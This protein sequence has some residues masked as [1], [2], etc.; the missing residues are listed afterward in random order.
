MADKIDPKILEAMKNSI[1]TEAQLKAGFGGKAF[2]GGKDVKGFGGKGMKAEDQT[3]KNRRLESGVA[4]GEIGRLAKQLEEQNKIAQDNKSEKDREKLLMDLVLA[5]EKGD[6]EGE[7]NALELRATYIATQERLEK[8]I[9]AGDNSLIELEQA[10]LDRVMAGAETEEKRREAA[11]ATEK[12]S[13]LLGKISSGIKGLSGFLK[14]NAVAIG[15]GLFAGLALFAPELMEKLVK[16]L[17]SVLQKAMEIVKALLDGDI[18]GALEAFKS[19]WLAFTGAFIFFF[20]DKIKN[21]LV[22]TFKAFGTLIKAVRTYRLFLATQY[23]GS[24]IAHL[25]DMMKN[26]GNTLMKPLRFLLNVAKGFRVFMMATF[27]PGMIAAF[28]GMIA[29][30]TPMLAALAPILLPILA[31]AA[32]FGL[33]YLALEKMREAMGFT[34]IFDVMLLGLAYLKD[35]F[36]HIVNLI[37]TIVNFIMGLVGK[38]ASFLGFD[39]DIPKIPK[40][41]T[42][43]ASRKKAELQEKAAEEAAAKKAKQDIDADPLTYEVD[44]TEPELS[45]TTIDSSDSITPES[46]RSRRR[47]RR[48]VRKSDNATGDNLVADSTAN[49]VLQEQTQTSAAAPVVIQQKGGD[50]VQNTTNNS[51]RSYRRNRGWRTQDLDSSFAH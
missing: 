5:T 16:K 15:G 38:F 17:V 9:E 37:G 47:G 43:N 18:D 30:I 20:G 24:M 23:S 33:I 39:I 2:E 19:E 22:G 49:V 11:K 34:S 26:L 7:K 1:M 48:S 12:Q 45:T 51:T 25:K 21:L 8:A 44:I 29:A 6:A 3:K 10:N 27:I 42:N 28:S 50:V 41:D 36:G 13:K 46:T 32:V 31:I 4:S 14:E 40:M 35:G